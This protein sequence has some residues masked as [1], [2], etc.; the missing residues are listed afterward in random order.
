MFK[1][2]L[3]VLQNLISKNSDFLKISEH[4]ILFVL[5]CLFNLNPPPSSIFSKNRDVKQTIKLERPNLRYSTY[6]RHGT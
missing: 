5:F 2:P 1:Y 6:I 3:K 4:F